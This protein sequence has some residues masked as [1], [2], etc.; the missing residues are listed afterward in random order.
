MF[1]EGD[2]LVAW[3]TMG[4][5]SQKLVRHGGGRVVGY[6]GPAASF[7][8]A[9]IQSFGLIFEE[10]QAVAALYDARTTVQDRRWEEREAL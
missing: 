1:G 3:G 8:V 4:I 5:G 6:L 10:Q 7:R 9:D 2:D